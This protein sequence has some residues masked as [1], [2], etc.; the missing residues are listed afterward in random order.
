MTSLS[1]LSFFSRSSVA[2]FQHHQ[3]MELTFH[4]SYV[5]LE[6]VASTV[7]F[8]T[9]LSYCRKRYSS[10]ATL[11]LSCSHRYKYST[12]V[13][14]IWLT[15]MNYPYLRWQWI[16]YFLRRCCFPLPLTRLI[17]DLTVY[18][19]NMSGGLSEAGTV[20]FSR[21]PEFTPCFLVGSVLK[22]FYKVLISVKYL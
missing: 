5:I 20:D 11:L 16:F 17:P 14:T 8:W 15:A 12:V 13:V 18:M 1:Q 9:K 7:I 19:S 21:A 22:H 6:L 2:I 10:K 3:R 4:N